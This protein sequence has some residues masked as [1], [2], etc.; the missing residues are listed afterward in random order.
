MSG[1]AAALWSSL[2]LFLLLVLSGLVVRQRRQHRIPVGDGDV[3]E[4][5]RALRA[6]GNAAEY[7]PAGLAALAVLTVAGANPVLIHVI[8][9]TLLVGRI[10]H[11]VGLSRTTSTSLG[12][13]VGMVLTWLA[14]LIAAVAL[15]AYSV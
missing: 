1:S 3:P 5:R 12:R 2:N 8:G 7:I 13:L 6:F 15:L 4:L 14:W 11:A 9:A 10:A